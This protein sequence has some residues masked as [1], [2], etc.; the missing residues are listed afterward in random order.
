MSNNSGK[1]TRY[2]QIKFDSSGKTKML[3]VGEDDG[4]ITTL[5]DK[6]KMDKID[7]RFLGIDCSFVIDLS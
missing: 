5:L 4:L 6:E 2:Y 7:V 3:K 1:I